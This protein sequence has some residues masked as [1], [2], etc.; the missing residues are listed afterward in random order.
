MAQVDPL[1]F[2]IGEIGLLATRFAVQLQAVF[3]K[4]FDN[5]VRCH[6]T[7]ACRPVN[8]TTRCNRRVAGGFC[9]QVYDVQA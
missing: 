5:L 4:D 7:D 6:L 1:E 2:G 3:D 8:E 9:N